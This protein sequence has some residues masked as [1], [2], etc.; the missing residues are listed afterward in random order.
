MK[1]LKYIIFDKC[2]AVLFNTAL[3]HDQIIYNERIPTSAGFVDIIYNK[4]TN[5]YDSTCYGKSISLAI[6]SNPIDDKQIIDLTIN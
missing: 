4:E 6:N 3:D 2:F 5:V 1:K